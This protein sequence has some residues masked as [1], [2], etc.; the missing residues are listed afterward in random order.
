MNIIVRFSV[1]LI[2]YWAF[3]EGQM[4]G[5]KDLELVL[6]TLLFARPTCFVMG[7]LGDNSTCQLWA[8]RHNN[9]ATDRKSCEEAFK[10]NCSSILVE[11]KWYRRGHKMCNYTD[12]TEDSS[13]ASLPHF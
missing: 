7:L 3:C 4:P 12:E 11:E 1:L 6:Y 13:T 8:Q 10:S 5:R 9:N 2:A